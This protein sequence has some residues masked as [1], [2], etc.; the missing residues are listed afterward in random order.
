M[1]PTCGAGARVF[2]KILHRYDAIL[3]CPVV[4]LGM[5][6]EEATTLGHAEAETVL[7][8]CLTHGKNVLLIG[9]H[10]TGKTSLI[11]RVAERA[12]LKMGEGFVYLSGATLDPWV[13]FVGVPRP[14]GEYLKF[15][16][17][18]YMDPDKVELLVIDEIN[19]SPQKVR[20]ACME[21]AQFKTV[22][23]V[24]FPR[25]RAVWACGNPAD[26]D[27]GY[28]DV[29]PIDVALADRFHLAF[30]LPS[31]PDQSHFRS[32]FGEE[33]GGAAVEWWKSIS[34]ESKRK[35]SP[36]RLEYAIHMVT[37]GMMA[38]LALPGVSESAYL[39]DFL[40][41][42]DP[43]RNI[44]RHMASGD[45]SSLTDAVLSPASSAAI[46][47]LVEND[48]DGFIEML[49]MLPVEHGVAM[50][51]HHHDFRS[52]VGMLYSSWWSSETRKD[53]APSPATP[54][55]H[56]LAGLSS[57]PTHGWARNLVVQNEPGGGL[58]FGDDISAEKFGR[59]FEQRYGIEDRSRF[60]FGVHAA[61]LYGKLSDTERARVKKIENACR[62]DMDTTMPEDLLELANDQPQ[63]VVSHARLLRRSLTKWA[64]PALEEKGAFGR[65]VLRDPRVLRSPSQAYGKPEPVQD[66]HIGF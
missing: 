32:I 47:S 61:G 38:Q 12:G 13:D 9:G 15:Y 36:R 1:I 17:P 63:L 52:A 14:E 8:A 30:R 42:D 33:R 57:N 51:A 37:M 46:S 53:A 48:M 5:N 39:G 26:P 44:R 60:Y 16:R 43:M 24:H 29:E 23:G 27:A 10:G 49:A 22:N 35:V 11:Q 20:N 56:G 65:I 58:F 18:K 2:L 62:N 50:A 66:L 41:G 64:I 28:T 55:V 21:M 59:L 40:R 31:D 19:R 3:R 4:P 25:L 45:I 54:I 7:S 34:L 6:P